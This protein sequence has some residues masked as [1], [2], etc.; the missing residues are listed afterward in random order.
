M[1]KEKVKAYVGL[2]RRA[3]TAACG[4][5]AAR[6][7]VRAGKAQLVLLASDTSYNTAKRAADMCEHY[8]VRLLRLDEDMSW[9]GGCVGQALT[10]A[11]AIG[12][13]GLAKAILSNLE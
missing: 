11:V 9:L 2:A 6:G 5:E 8:K 13:K 7:M 12:D 4:L 10:A 1:K 3:G